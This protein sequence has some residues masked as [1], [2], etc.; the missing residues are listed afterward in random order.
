MIFFTLV[1]SERRGERRLGGS[2]GT[3]EG[4]VQKKQNHHLRVRKKQNHHLRG[5]EKHMHYLVG[6][7]GGSR[8]GR[9]E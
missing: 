7:T 1:V 8:E 5:E 2:E 3:K 6:G 9:R 4:G